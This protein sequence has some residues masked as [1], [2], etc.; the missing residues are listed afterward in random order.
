MDSPPL[1]PYLLLSVLHI[2]LVI[3]FK[4]FSQSISQIIVMIDYS[5]IMHCC[6]IIQMTD[7]YL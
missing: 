2:H 3:F 1:L 7:F 6:V 5:M 4:W